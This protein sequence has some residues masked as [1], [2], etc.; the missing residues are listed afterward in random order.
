MFTLHAVSDVQSSKFY[1]NASHPVTVGCAITALLS[2]SDTPVNAP[3][4]VI[5]TAEYRRILLLL[6]PGHTFE[7]A[8]RQLDAKHK[9]F[10]DNFYEGL[11]EATNS[12]R[13]HSSILN[14]LVADWDSKNPDRRGP[15]PEEVSLARA[16]VEVA[17]TLLKCGEEH[18]ASRWISR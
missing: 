10:T 16:S 15:E 18:R 13:A 6:C 11:R 12:V 7:Y 14:A 17:D 2:N 5:T 9:E 4:P 1:L 8:D 3:P